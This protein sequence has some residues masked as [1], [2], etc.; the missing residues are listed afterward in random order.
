[1]PE[2]H[3]TQLTAE[4]AGPVDR[5]ARIAVPRPV[6]RWALLAFAL[7]VLAV[8]AV[9]TA[10]AFPGSPAKADPAGPG[11]VTRQLTPPPDRAP[12]VPGASGTFSYR[13]KVWLSV[14]RFEGLTPPPPGRR[15]LVFVRYGGE[16]VVAGAVEPDVAG[17]AEVRYRAVPAPWDLFEVMV[18]TDADTGVPS[19]HGTLV[20]RWLH[21]DWQRWDKE[22]WPLGAVR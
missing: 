16:W 6:R 12:A 14:F 7:I 5:P 18:T 19:P 2:P 4:R 1:V 9:R 11:V 10:G 13:P 22:P 3:G 15:Y 8:L 21:P 17:R 20:L